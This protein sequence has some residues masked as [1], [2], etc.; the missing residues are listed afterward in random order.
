VS[1][2]RNRYWLATIGILLVVIVVGAARLLNGSTSASVV[3]AT[4][5]T[6]SSESALISPLISATSGPASRSRVPA[7]N[8]DNEGVIPQT[9]DAPAVSA[10]ASGPLDGAVTKASQFARAWLAHEG[11]TPDTW[12]KDLAPHAT[13]ALLA[14]LRNTDPTSVPASRITGQV[15]AAD[16]DDSYVEAQVPANGG[17]I[18]LRLLADSG[19][20]WVDGV[21]WERS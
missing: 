9:P 17:T 10:G 15:T 8:P 13:P 12:H 20:W 1:I 4:P 11:V 3:A 16:I 19:H 5:V 14:K 18:V 6:H 2:L 7:I 21:D